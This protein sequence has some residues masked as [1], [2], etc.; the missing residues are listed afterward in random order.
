[1]AK[2]RSL[3]FAFQVQIMDPELVFRT[4]GFINFVS[5]WL[6]RLVDPKKSHPN[7]LVEYVVP[8]STRLCQN[9]LNDCQATFATG[10]T[11]DI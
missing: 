6:I 7:P 2:I 4:V 11:N 3:Q 9:Q 1:M 10:R 8:I 5:T